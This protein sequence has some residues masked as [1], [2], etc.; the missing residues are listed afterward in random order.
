LSWWVNRGPRSRQ[1]PACSRPQARGSAPGWSV[2]LYASGHLRDQFR[3]E[4]YRGGDEGRMR[5]PCSLVAAYLNAAIG[6]DYPY[7]LSELEGMWD[8]ASDGDVSDGE[9][10]ALH[11]A[12]HAAKN[13][14]QPAQQ[15]SLRGLSKFALHARDKPAYGVRIPYRHP[16]PSGFGWRT[17][18]PD[19]VLAI[20]S[21]GEDTAAPTGPL[22]YEWAARPLHV[23][24]VRRLEFEG[25]PPIGRSA[26]GP[27]GTNQEALIPKGG[28]YG[29]PFGVGR[30]HRSRRHHRSR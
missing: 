18:T 19:C 27:S 26:P 10:H 14:Q 2:W 8:D 23:Q 20:V 4:R 22:P 15:R 12:L 1:W 6:L 21:Y 29:P 16:Y 17:R 9:L 7:T 25:E 24:A 28:P 11:I 30:R 3:G 13:R 5:A